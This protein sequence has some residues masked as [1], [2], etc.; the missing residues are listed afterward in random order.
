MAD[1]KDYYETLGVS[2]SATADEIKKAY[3]SLAKKYHPDVNKEP[4]AEE[5][6]KEI[7]EAYSVLGDET[8]RKNYD[9]YGNADGPAGFGGAGCGGGAGGFGGFGDFEDIFSSFFGGG[10][11]S[12]RQSNNRGQDVE[13]SMTITFEEAVFGA[14]KTVR[15]S[16]DEDCPTCGGSGAY[17]KNDIHTC[18][19]CGGQGYVF[20]NQRT[21]FGTARSQVVCPT[22]GGRGQQIDKKCTNCGGS[23]RVR[24]TKDVDL[25]IPAGIDEGMTL[26]MSGYGQGGKD[27]GENG[28]L[29]I[30]IHVTPHKFFK[31]EGSDIMLE[32]PISFTQAALGDTLD[33]PTID[34]TAALKIPAGT[35][36]GTR[37]RIKG[38][39]VK[40]VRSSSRGDQYVTVRVETPTSLSKEEKEL[41]E[42]LSNVEKT[43]KKS[44]WEKFKDL[45]KK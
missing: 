8:K 10:S 18:S 5:K 31:R 42:K 22:C 27:G 15:V 36:S 14:K 9:Q 12:Q 1:K 44:A 43:E 3:R 40:S 37:F 25:T 17:S 13:K 28:D 38:K 16:V 39:G 23:G 6:F 45:F 7:N 41:F 33:V 34:G 30:L 26:R 2:K 29:F 24:R 21:F 20:V 19:K 4:G 32:V 35:Q 11:R